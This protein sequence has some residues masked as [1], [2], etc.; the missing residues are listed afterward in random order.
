MGHTVEYSFNWGDGSSPSPWST[1]TSASHTWTDTNQH[2]VTATARCQTHND[3][4]NTSDGLTITPI[5]QE[6]ISKLGTPTGESSPTVGQ[7]YT[8]ST[9]GATS[10]LGH[11]VEYSFNWG[12][13]SSP[14]PWS[15]STSAFHTWSDMNPHTVTVTARCQTHTN[16]TN[17]SDGLTVNPVQQ[18]TISKPG[19]PTG[20]PRPVVGQSYTY[21]TTGATSNLGHT[22]VYS[23]DWSDGSAPSPWSTSTCASHTWTDTIP[24]MVRVRAR[25]QIHTNITNISDGLRVNRKRSIAP[26]LNILLDD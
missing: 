18:E 21:C 9:S 25:C 13:G 1:S 12:D 11:Q 8:Y 5:P 24:H 14:S 10:S 3:I 26:I 19:R 20:E 4:T 15:T 6:S 22:V 23:F 2:T 16:I 7:S 17:T